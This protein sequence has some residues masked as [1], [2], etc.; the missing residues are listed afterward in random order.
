MEDRYPQS[1][2]LPGAALSAPQVSAVSDPAWVGGPGHTP[3]PA[4]EGI[5]WSRYQSAVWRQKWLLAGL[6][7]VG[8]AGGIAAS[9]F[10]HPAYDVRATVWVNSSRDGESTSG[11]IRAANLLQSTAWVELFRSFTITDSVVNQLRLYLTPA[12]PADSALFEHFHHADDYATGSF[13]LRIDS[14]GTRY[15]ILDAQNTVR[16]QGSTTDSLGQRLG[17]RWT[18]PAAELRPRRQAR[19]RVVTA[20]DASIGLLNQLAAVLPEDGN[21]LRLQLSGS[22]P[23]LIARTLNTWAAQFVAQA[24]ALKKRNLVEFEKILDSQLVV[25]ESEMRNAEIALESFRVNTI[26]LPSEGGPVA[27]GLES[28]RDP[29]MQSYF[30]QK[31]DYDELHH[32]REALERVIDNAPDGRLTPEALLSVPGAMS[33]APNL[34]AALAELN[35]KQAQLRAARQTLTDAHPTVRALDES[36]RVLETQTIPALARALLTQLQDRERDLGARIDGASAELRRIPPR[37]IEEL[38][39]R[40]QVAV[41]ENLYNM[42]KSRYEEARL[43][44]AGAT[45]DVSVLDSAVAPLRPSSNGAPRVVILAILTTLG[46]GVALAILLDR[47]D[48]RFRYPSQ[49]TRDLGLAVIGAVPSLKCRRDGAVDLD[50]MTRTV[51]AFRT[52]RL[53]I[54]YALGNSGPIVLTISSPGAGDGKSVVSANLALSFANAG[55]RTVIIDGDVRR[56]QL[57]DTFA[58]RRA[59][60]LSDLLRAS[61]AGMEVALQAVEATPKLWMISR[62]SR[63]ESAPELLGSEETRR[64]VYALR[65]QF[66]VVIIDSPPLSAGVD[67]YALGVVSEAILL[68]LRAGTTDRKLAEAKLQVLDRLPVRLVGA[69]LNDIGNSGEYRYYTYKYG[70]PKPSMTKRAPLRIPTAATVMGGQGI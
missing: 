66:D 22:D 42:L 45:P 58:T 18:A 31:T 32:D 68:V 1:P 55:Y 59:P 38:R 50:L 67:A 10:V 28:T 3:V 19:F 4:E 33:N 53:S 27:A 7:A 48:R 61:G 13:V 21:F 12:I 46:L 69:V 9:R 34:Q 24:A 17:F 64:L 15:T 14:T 2:P 5:P 23:K 62:G 26:T 56:G 49:A 20:R 57:H 37:T 35:S 16:D 30:R 25:A 54:R 6:L 51:E 39:L 43:T 52:L 41:S 70:E 8:S 44:E 40:R 29:V 11:P 60:G 63:F 47:L 36:V 65:D